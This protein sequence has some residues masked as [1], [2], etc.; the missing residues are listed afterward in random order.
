MNSLNLLFYIATVQIEA[1]IVM[2]HKVIINFV[3]VELYRLNICFF[4]VTIPGRR[5]RVS[6]I[7]SP[8]Q[9]IVYL[10]NIQ[11]YTFGV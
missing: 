11:Y 5:N 7:P 9:Y 10:E 4:Q 3:S 8:L 6:I 2:V 1:I